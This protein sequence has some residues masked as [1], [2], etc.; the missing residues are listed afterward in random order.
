MVKGFPCQ[1]VHP[2]EMQLGDCLLSRP[3][4]LGSSRNT[5]GL[6]L[7]EQ[8]AGRLPGIPNVSRWSAMHEGPFLESTWTSHVELLEVRRTRSKASGSFDAKAPGP[9]SELQK[10]GRS[11]GALPPV[12]GVGTA[13]PAPHTRLLGAAAPHDARGRHRLP[14]FRLTALVVLGP[15][16]VFRPFLQL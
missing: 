4:P 12:Q 8:A 1:V 7:I 13:D 9:D 5:G 6:L 11:H 2:P 10:A 16:P 14:C 3:Q 15:D